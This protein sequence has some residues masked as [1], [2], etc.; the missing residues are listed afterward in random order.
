MAALDTAPPRPW[1]ATTMLPGPVRDS[2]SAAIRLSGGGGARRS[3]AGNTAPRCGLIRDESDSTIE[4]VS[5]GRAV[6][7]R[8]RAATIGLDAW[9]LNVG[10]GLA[11][12]WPPV[13][14]RV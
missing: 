3:S 4:S 11:G 7:G 8:D 13:S 2:I 1:S 14:Q 6:P 9:T 12:G 10:R 5:L